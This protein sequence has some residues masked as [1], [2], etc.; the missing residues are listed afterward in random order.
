MFLIIATSSKYHPF[1]QCVFVH[2]NHLARK[3]ATSV[4]SCFLGNGELCLF[5]LNGLETLKTINQ[6]IYIYIYVIFWINKTTYLSFK[7]IL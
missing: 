5:I 2:Y 4:F 7:G 6:D 1:L 3:S